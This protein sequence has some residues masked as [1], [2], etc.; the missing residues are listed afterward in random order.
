MAKVSLK[1]VD[2]DTGWTDQQ[3]RQPH[4]LGWTCI[5]EA[6]CCGY[7]DIVKTILE[8]APHDEQ[9]CVYLGLSLCEAAENNDLE[10][11][12]LLLESGETI[13]FPK[14]P[15]EIDE[16]RIC[17]CLY[18]VGRGPQAC[19][20]PDKRLVKAFLNILPKI[21]DKDRFLINGIAGAAQRG[22]LRLMKYLFQF[23]ADPLKAPDETRRAFELAAR[24]DPPAATL[25]SELLIQHG[26]DPKISGKALLVAFSQ[27]NLALARILIEKGADVD[28]DYELEEKESEDWEG[29]TPLNLCILQGSIEGVRLLLEFGADVQFTG[30]M[31]TLPLLTAMSVDDP[32]EEIT[33]MLLARGAALHFDLFS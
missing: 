33:Q 1:Y 20:R 12:N 30:E 7:V 3:L 26:A 22:D 23:G 16:R 11:I 32:K 21:R 10:M 17:E 9:G 4:W 6:A 29:Q 14:P 27:G 24:L 5:K 15:L 28:A 31:V 8:H 18:I 13:L 19:G 2:F 25:A